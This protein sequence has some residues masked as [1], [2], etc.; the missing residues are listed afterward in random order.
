VTPDIDHIELA[1]VG[2]DVGS[3]TTHLMFS[4][5]DL[6]RAAQDLSSRYEVVARRVT[7]QSP[8][9]FTPYT[10]DET[11][12]AAALQ[13]FVRRGFDQ[14]GQSP[15]ALGSGAVLLTGTALYRHNARAIADGLARDAGP[16]VCAAA[17]PHLEAVLAAHGSGA[18]AAAQQDATT[19]VNLDV[20]GGTAKFALVAD[21]QVQRTAAVLAGS[22]LAAWDSARRLVRLEP[23]AVLAGEQAGLALRRGEQLSPDGAAA[24]SAVLARVVVAQLTGGPATALDR[25]LC[26]TRP[27]GP[28]DGE[29]Q[30]ML[31]GG[32]AECL[33]QDGAEEY[34]DLGPALAIA[35]LDELAAAG[36]AS[37]LRPA[38]HRLR[39]TVIGVSQFGTQ[40][41]G[42][43]VHVPEAAGL[44]V[45]DVPVVAPRLDLTGDPD[46]ARV[47]AA[48]TAAI[49]QR[50]HEPAGAR[51]LTLAVRWA[52]PP[53]YHR[54]R[55]V[56]EGIARGVSGS[57]PE[58]TRPGGLVVLV[59]D[60]DL[61]ASIGRIL[62]DDLGWRG[63]ALL[64]L[65]GLEVGEL[66]F[67]DIGRP[68]PS[69][70][71]CPVVVKSLLFAG[72]KDEPGAVPG[73][74]MAGQEGG[75]AR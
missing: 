55:A 5:V 12:D 27:F 33:E 14:A 32:V 34:L 62:V 38:R 41:S 13:L 35:L 19:I 50:S 30:L 57:L 11:I 18:V 66:D 71:A 43:T 54:L 22:R 25:A 21:G 17:G 7:W 44:P 51:R 23:A 67:L 16:F 1:T 64:C 15:A 53:A 75:Q 45:H 65:D 28:P 70:G 6:A 31:S 29:W 24:L 46:P 20:G 60:A 58:L 2:I 49:T 36:L 10:D 8:V 40:V 63:P 3:A 42:A 73:H 39:A 26:L 52:G 48:V 37:S 72:P 69:G 74:A 68:A 9:A 56:A 47:A 59:V 61:A 4:Q